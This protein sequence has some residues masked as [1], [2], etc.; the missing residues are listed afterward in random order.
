MPVDSLRTVPGVLI[1]HLADNTGSLILDSGFDLDHQILNN[2]TAFGLT[3]SMGK[4]TKA[5]TAP[6]TPPCTKS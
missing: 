5:P 6:A 3:R 2:L 4:T 1:E